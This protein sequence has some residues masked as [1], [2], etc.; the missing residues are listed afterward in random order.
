MNLFKKR[1]MISATL[2]V[3]ISTQDIKQLESNVTVK[4]KH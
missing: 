1:T 2:T 4:Q 3:N